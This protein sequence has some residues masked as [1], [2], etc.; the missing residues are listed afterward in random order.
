MAWIRLMPW[1]KKLHEKVFG[2]RLFVTT[3][4]ALVMPLV[5]A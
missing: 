2:D 1:Q 5:K 4:A 3:P